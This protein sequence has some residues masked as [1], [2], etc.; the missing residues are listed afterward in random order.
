MRKAGLKEACTDRHGPSAPPTYNRSSHPI[1]G[2]Y[3]SESLLGSRC[4]YLKFEYD[5]RGLFL[6]VQ[7]NHVFGTSVPRTAKRR[8]RRL[9]CDDPRI[10]NNFTRKYKEFITQHHLDSRATQLDK[11][12]ELEIN[13]EQA[14]RWE[15]ID[16]MR[17]CGVS[18]AD[19]HCRKFKTGEAPWSFE[20]KIERAIVDFWNVFY[21]LRN[22]GRGHN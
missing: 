8:G 4:G 18:H 21:K 9:K 10:V 15:A 6:D 3:V 22:E 14:A 2:I 5:H 12:T 19:L 7:M 13:S 1:D 11:E 16:A 17:V 20:F